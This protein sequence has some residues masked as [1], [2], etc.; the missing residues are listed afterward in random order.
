MVSTCNKKLILLYLFWK[1]LAC[2]HGNLDLVK[3]L[4]ENGADPKIKSKNGKT[5]LDIGE[6][7][8]LYILYFKKDYF[9]FS[10]FKNTASEKTNKAII[11]EILKKMC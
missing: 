7:I 10:T 4:L 6:W 3:F 2:E 11:M 5:A 8:N 9:E 1:C